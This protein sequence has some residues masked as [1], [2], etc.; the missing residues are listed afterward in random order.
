MSEPLIPTA[1]TSR[2]VDPLLDAA[3]DSVVE[4]VQSVASGP[5][6]LLVRRGTHSLWEATAAR[7]RHRGF[8]VT[9]H[10]LAERSREWDPLALHEEHSGHDVLVHHDPFLPGEEAGSPSDTARELLSRGCSLVFVDFP[11][12]MRDEALARRLAGIYL[13]ALAARP[14][15]LRAAAGR[16]RAELEGAHSLEIRSEAGTLRILRPWVIRDDWTSASE[17][18]PI[19]QLPGAEVWLA[20]EPESVSG[21]IA[22]TLRTHPGLEVV[23]GRIRNG[24]ARL[25][26]EPIVEVGIGVNPQATWL[27]GTSLTEKAAGRLH[28]GFGDNALL[29][30]S[31]HRATH[32]DIP[33]SGNS[34]AWVVSGSGRDHR[35]AHLR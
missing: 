6:V 20:C 25:D 22:T 24:P 5:G 17:D 14:D 30:G 12:G 32:F 13:R 21:T 10:D 8:R 19:R 15:A 16:L 23:A 9:R 31:R 11:A 34:Q 7:L 3:V 29:G 27:P 26:V 1:E 4:A 28:L 35:V 18:A 33:L 2:G